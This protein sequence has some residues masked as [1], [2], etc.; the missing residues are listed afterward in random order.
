[1]PTTQLTNLLNVK[2]QV[3][4]AR[5]GQHGKL[6]EISPQGRVHY[7]T[8]VVKDVL[9]F[10]YNGVT[11][12]PPYEIES[13]TGD[14]ILIGGV[15]AVMPHLPPDYRSGPDIQSLNI[16]NFLPWGLKMYHIT[17]QGNE[18]VALISP[19]VN[20]AVSNVYY[21]NQNEGIKIGD[22]FEI[23]V[24]HPGVPEKLYSFMVT[25]KHLTTII[26]GSVTTNSDPQAQSFQNS[27]SL[28]S[29]HSKRSRAPEGYSI[30]S[31]APRKGACLKNE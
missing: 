14:N 25:D 13:T 26:I 31:Q 30:L 11:V 29:I 2:I 3:Y 19:C 28:T 7:T 1:M 18:L 5:N 20:G 15:S 27:Y 17:Q 8:L 22:K 16:R 4:V 10:T 9:Y 21:D 12:A 24:S 6:G 23:E